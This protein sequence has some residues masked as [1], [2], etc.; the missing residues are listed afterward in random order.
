MKVTRHRVQVPERAAGG[1]VQAAQCGDAA[2]GETRQHPHTRGEEPR[3]EQ[4][5]QQ[6]R[7]QNIVR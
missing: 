2:A 1:G 7:A 5:R 6:R 3:Q 4:V